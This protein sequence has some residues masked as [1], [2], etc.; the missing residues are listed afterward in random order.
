MA[1]VRLKGLN[2]VTKRLKDGRRITYWYA[3]RGGPRLDGHPGAP[4]FI[5]SFNRAVAERRST[6][7]A[8]LSGLVVRYKASPEYARLSESTRAHWIRWL[9]RLMQRGGPADIGGLPIAALDDRRV[10][11][12][13]LAWRDQWADRPRSADYAMQV[14]S[15]VLGWAV[16][17][18]MLALNPVAG[19]E[20]LYAGGRA[21]QVW[22]AGELARYQAAAPSPEV[23]AIVPLACLTGLRRED[24][25]TLQ[26]AHVGDVAIVKPTGK[27]RGR[28]TAVVPLLPETRQ[29]L[30]EIRAQQQRRQ[31]EL[32]ARAERHGRAPPPAALT[33]LTNT[34]GQPWSVAGLE[35]Q[36]VDTKAKAAIDK[37]LHDAR[38]TFGTRLR[39][40]GLSASEIADI[41]GWDEVRVERLLSTY[42][43]RDGIVLSI[44]RRIG[45]NESGA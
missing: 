39:K 33:V 42:V 14:L 23:A 27:S 13:I 12:E 2:R 40:A 11:Q 41:L 44:A 1:L 32:A 38:G 5:A 18:G 4:E 36:V 29:L 35:H 31:A 20:Q 8:T 10:R 3:W 30:D 22:T 34:R 43:D 17:R 26:W 24:L 45:R 37:H 28:K 25:A 6:G 21:E 9:D 19:V 7:D 16:G 15:R